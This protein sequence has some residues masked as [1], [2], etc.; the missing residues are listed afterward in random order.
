[1][2]K[3]TGYVDHIIFRN[4]DTGYT[5]FVL[6][7]GDGEVTCVGSIP[8]LTEGELVDVEGS[9]ALHPTYGMQWQVQKLTE[10]A[11]KDTESIMRYLGSGAIRGVG[12][13]LAAAIVGHFGED[14]FRVIEEEPERL[15]EIKGISERKAR[16]IGTQIEEKRDMRQAMMYMGGFGITPHLSAKIYDF[17]GEKLYTILKNNPYKL[18]EDIEGVGFKTADDIAVKVGIP[19]DSRFR[20]R[21]GIL[22]ALQQGI[23]EGHVF[24]PDEVL[25]RRTCELLTVDEFDLDEL[26]LDLSIDRL[27]VV[28]TVEDD[29]VDTPPSRRVYLSSFYYMELY[30]AHM[31]HDL[32]I[33]E[34]VDEAR[35]R[36]RLDRFEKDLEMELDEQQKRAV[37]TM[38]ESGILLLTGGPGTGK[39]TTV[40]AMIRCAVAERMSFLLAAPTGRAAKRMT[41]TSGFEAKTIHRLLE[42]GA[43]E[44]G[45]GMFA[46][47]EENPLEA[48]IIIIDEMSMVDLPLMYALL[49]AIPVGTHVVFAGDQNQ[50]PSVGCGSVLKDMIASHHFPLVM[51]TKIFRQEGLS[52]IVINAHK[53]NKGEEIALD[54]KSEDFFM[55]QRSDE[56]VIREVLFSLLNEKLPRYL[57]VDRGEIQVLT[58]MRRGPLGVMQLNEF[59]QR[60]LNPPAES[61]A[62]VMYSDSVFRRGDKVMQIKNNYR[63]SW[64]IRGR[65]GI[66]LEQGEGVFNGDMGR[67]ILADPVRE[68]VEVLFDEERIVTYERDE[69]TELELA[70]AVTI[71][72]SQGSEYPAVVLPLLSGPGQLMNRNLLY[73]AVTRAKRMVVIVGRRETVARMIANS[74]ENR[75]YS[76]LDERIRET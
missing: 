47:N 74:R 3:I 15:A 14:T 68:E 38:F 50:L 37:I 24:L 28:E 72:K 7:N 16:S 59:F 46:R 4:E 33:R 35:I 71:H 67:V 75:R 69:L 27:I 62:E 34:E 56:Q 11:P 31:L 60:T 29:S 18:A 5:V 21:C 39:T 1:M 26:L 25:Y 45:E 10:R 44:S 36:K 63:K 51:L 61:K 48:D 58:P 64:E 8:F 52:D 23:A 54:N 9:F 12:E 66:V 32:N 70:Y 22:F 57:K 17:Y 43:G 13:K 76:A 49:K 6:E 20:I 65:N 53:I 2:D 19:R 42:V 30:T 40:N 41:E 55:M 73:T